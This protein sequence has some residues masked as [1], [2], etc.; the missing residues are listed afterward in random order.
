M[1]E[2]EDV[3][4][5]KIKLYRGNGNSEVKSVASSWTPRDYIAINFGH[6]VSVV[7]APAEAVFLAND[8]MNEDYWEYPQEREFVLVPGLLSADKK[9]NP[10]TLASEFRQGILDKQLEQQAEAYDK[11]Y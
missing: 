5:G 4:N 6:N 7:D 10:E 9:L 8:L 3:K 1:K 2:S 11:K